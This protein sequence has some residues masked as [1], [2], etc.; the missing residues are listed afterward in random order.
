MYID[1]KLFKRQLELEQ[2]GIQRGI[3]K[4]RK[5]VMEAKAKG[6]YDTTNL[7]CSIIQN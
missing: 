6:S 1:P 7:K 3:E 4:F 5:E 2:E